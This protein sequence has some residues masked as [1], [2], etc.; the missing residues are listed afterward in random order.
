MSYSCIQ[1]ISVQSA[2]S[3]V[4]LLPIHYNTMKIK[5]RTTF[6]ISDI[7]HSFIIITELFRVIQL[8]VGEVELES[9]CPGFMFPGFPPHVGSLCKSLTPPKGMVEPVKVEPFHLNLLP[10]KLS[11]RLGVLWSRKQSPPLCLWLFLSYPL[12]GFTG[13]LLWDYALPGI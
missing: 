11:L 7:N 4:S 8:V 5:R 6:S 2:F 13:L 3:H 10:V 1:C 12:P 9:K